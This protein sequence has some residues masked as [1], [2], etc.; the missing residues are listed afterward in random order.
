MKL[1]RQFLFA[2]FILV[3]AAA[4]VIYGNY[5]TLPTHNTAATHFDAI[6]VLGTPSKPDGTP[7]PEQRERVLE[8]VREYKAGIAPRLIMTGGAAHNH[9]VEAHS[10]AVYAAEQGVPAT[11]I[12]EE[13]QAQNTIQNIYYS[14]TI[15]HQHGWSSA[16]IVSSPYHLGRTALI[17]N[18]FNTR[19]PALSIDWRT[20]PSN[21]PPEYDIHHKVVLYSVEAWRCLQLRLQGSRFLPV[22][23]T[24]AIAH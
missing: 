14:A 18:A 6:I 24:P 17:M 21:W 5:I 1:L 3:F 16:E 9:F 11:D 23:G 15:M 19:Q 4:L 10:M 7:S 22:P 2:V 20:H 12:I 8:G 13:G